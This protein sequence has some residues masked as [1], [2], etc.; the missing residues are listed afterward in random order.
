M[1]EQNLNSLCVFM[2]FPRSGQPVLFLDIYNLD[3]T[4]GCSSCDFTLQFF[5]LLP[6][7]IH[8]SLTHVQRCHFCLLQSS[9]QPCIYTPDHLLHGKQCETES[10]KL[11]FVFCDFQINS[12]LCLKP[13]GKVARMKHLWSPRAH[14]PTHYIIPLLESTSSHNLEQNDVKYCC[15]P[16]LLQVQ[17]KLKR[18][19]S[20]YGNETYS[21]E[22]NATPHQTLTK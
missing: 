6:T 2:V 12:V 16:Y 15:C 5:T 21:L 7:N 17:M 3:L 22:L 1:R 19:P 18:F 14:H 20:P 8:C 10:R 11:T 13:Q 9:C 4:M